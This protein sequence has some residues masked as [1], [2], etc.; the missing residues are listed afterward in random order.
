MHTETISI[1]GAG[2]HA[3]VV[4]DAL[5]CNGWI[6]SQIKVFVDDE[7]LLGS[8][9]LGCSIDSIR[10]LS[11]SESDLIHSAVGEYSSRKKLLLNSRVNVKKWAKIIHPKSIVSSFSDV[12][13]GSF[14]AAN[15]ILAPLV[16]VGK[17]TIINH[18]AVIDHESI[19]GEFCHIAPGVIISGG[20]L[21]GN[22]S[23]IG[24][25]ARVLPGVTIGDNVVVGAGAVVV[26]NIPDNEVW[27]GVPA[28]RVCK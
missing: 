10:N 22:C 27:Y 26:K 14:I 4:I 24:S 5:F 19:I 6:V 8:N 23:F 3:H 12:D 20:V 21:I 13:F 18:S 17:G 28:R 11:D 15:S 2:G 16:K 9:I 1:L 25:G 7:T